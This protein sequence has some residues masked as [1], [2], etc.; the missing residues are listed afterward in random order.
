M[1]EY[2][3]LI[4]NVIVMIGWQAL[5]MMLGIVIC[6]F[7]QSVDALLCVITI[8]LIIFALALAVWVIWTI[9]YFASGGEE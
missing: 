2:D 7:V 4:S 5:F 1:S 6:A 9:C 3:R 8:T